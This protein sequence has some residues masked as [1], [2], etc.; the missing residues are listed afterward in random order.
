M[1]KKGIR[2]LVPVEVVNTIKPNGI[3]D[4]ITDLNKNNVFVKHLLDNSGEIYT[5]GGKTNGRAYAKGVTGLLDLPTKVGTPEVKPSS[6]GLVLDVTQDDGFRIINTDA[7]VLGSQTGFTVFGEFMI[8]SFNGNRRCVF[9]RGAA[10]SSST[11]NW[12]IGCYGTEYYF[13][14]FD[15]SAGSMGAGWSAT[16]PTD[17]WIT[18]VGVYDYVNDESRLYVDGVLRSNINTPGQVPKLNQDFIGLGLGVDANNARNFDGQITYAGI[19]ND[20]MAT[21]AEAKAWA[22][23]PSDIWKPQTQWLPA[24][25]A[26]EEELSLLPDGV[27]LTEKPKGLTPI[28]KDNPLARD[29]IAFVLFNGKGEAIYNAVTGEYFNEG[30]NNIDG[31][32]L[33]RST[34]LEGKSITGGSGNTGKLE[35]HEDLIT[36]DYDELTILNRVKYASNTVDHGM[37]QTDVGLGLGNI[38]VWAD[39]ETGVGL[40]PGAYSGN[41]TEY[42]ASNTIPVNEWV[43]WGVNFPISDTVVMPYFYLNGILDSTILGNTG[44]S[45]QGSPI[46]FTYLNR[47]DGSRPLYGECSW[48]AVWGRGLSAEEHKEFNRNPYQIL[49]PRQDYALPHTINEGERNLIETQSKSISSKKLKQ[50]TPVNKSHS[51][52]RDMIAFVL[53]NGRGEA[54][55]NAVTG[56][57]FNEGTNNIDG[58]QLARS[59]G[60]EGRSVSGGSGNTG[61]LELHEDL[62]KLDYAYLT[63]LNRVKYDSA[64]DQG[65]FQIGNAT[66]LGTVLLW[67]DLDGGNLR[68]G[69]YSGVAGYGTGNSLPVGEWVTWGGNYRIDISNPICAFYTNGQYDTTTGDIG[70]AIDGADAPWTYLNK[71]DEGRPLYGECSWIAVWGRGLSAEEHKSF[72]DNP[73]QILQS[74]TEFIQTDAFI[75]E[76]SG[77][78]NLIIQDSLHGH[79][80][81]N[82]VLTQLHLLLVQDALHNHAADNVT[83]ESGVDLLIEDGLHGHLADILGLTQDHIL[84]VNEALHSH[85]AD[86]LDLT[87]DHQLAVNEALHSQTAD[88]PA[89]TQDHQL[90]VN[91]SL[92]TH[93]ADNLDLTQLHILT[94]SEALHGHTADSLVLDTATLL[95]IANALHAHT[96]DNLNLTQ[97]HQLLINEA[98]HSQTAD[99]PTMT[100]DHQL[101]IAE[102][103][104]SHT[105]D[106]L[107]LTQENTL[108]IAEA[109]H[110]HVSDAVVLTQDHQLT[111]AD[112]IHSHT[113]ETITLTQDHILIVSDSLHML[114]SDLVTLVSFIVTDTPSSRVYSIEVGSRIYLIVPNSEGRTYP[115]SKRNRVYSIKKVTL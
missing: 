58:T 87:Q 61:R 63:V 83:L 46:P 38:L 113:G 115:V 45:S 24:F 30:T 88:T 98:L 110:A 108:I 89:L 17:T 86:N 31:T 25:A 7:D 47:Y 106:G 71:Y 42:G 66:A 55:Y 22:A 33:S 39:Y 82:T 94:I 97:D 79:V 16:V 1:S 59:V 84:I 62:T 78:V 44:D 4:D 103:L 15:T 13:L 92:H 85:V 68:P 75:E 5:V 109:L 48:I 93:T 10:D 64:V 23:N 70:N 100:Q 96:G 36:A 41:S 69:A 20:Y 105:G 102:A 29:M 99:S 54:I 26:V 80:T 95:V 34:G 81:D 50:L 49:K 107:T 90:S 112:A 12:G 35:L 11:I 77:V 9:H 21:D 8:R 74:R 43:T 76:I 14:C 65:M 56:K 2:K 73:Y 40:R 6:R 67:A 114:V 27:P 18:I 37:F 60:S 104:H 111:I 19:I 28:N 53:F 57:Y 52:A 72:N 91:E 3:S 32:Q 51:L 101:V